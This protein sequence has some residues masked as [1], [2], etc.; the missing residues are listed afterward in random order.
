MPSIGL[1]VRSLE[2]WGRKPSTDFKNKKTFLPFSPLVLEVLGLT[3]WLLSADTVVIFDS[4]W[5]PMNDLQAIARA[6]RKG[7]RKKV[8]VYRL[9]TRNCYEQEMFKR[10]DQ[11]LALQQVVMGDVKDMNK[12]DIVTILRKGVI[13]MFLDEQKLDEE[14]DEFDKAD[15]EEILASRTEK[16]GMC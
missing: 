15:I 14:I 13:S 5:N 11:K 2:A 3:I 1:M 6:H 4:D 12:A 8:H 16:V 9:I 7:Q 10:A